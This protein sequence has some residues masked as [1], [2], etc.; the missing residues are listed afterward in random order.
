[1]RGYSS[2]WSTVRFVL[3]ANL[4]SELHR[5]EEAK[6]YLRLAEVAIEDERENEKSRFQAWVKTVRVRLG[7]GSTG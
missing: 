6:E 5:P 2:R 7:L 4:S 3:L 1:M